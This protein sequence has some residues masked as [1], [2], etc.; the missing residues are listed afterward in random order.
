[1]III[2]YSLSVKNYSRGKGYASVSAAA[3]RS[4]ERLN[5]HY[6]GQIYDY[7]K[8]G[9][10][11]HRQIFLPSTAPK[12]YSNRETLWNEVER[13]EKRSNARLAKEV[14]VALPKELSLEDNIRMVDRYVTDNFINIG[15][16]ADVTIHDKGDGNPHAHILLTTRSVT[17]EGFNGNKDRSWD[18]KAV[19]VQWRR[20][21]A[22]YLNREY[23]RQGLDCR[24][25]HRSYKEQGIDREPT[26]HLGHRVLGLEREGIRTDRGDEYR[27]IVERNRIREEQEREERER[28]RERKRERS[29]DRGR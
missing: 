17:P 12:E 7:T 16:C 21:W 29:L 14:R 6:N 27:A 23:E 10:I 24:V 11:V 1:V 2:L 4:G 3:Y 18:T 28:Q 26:I 20:E 9:G 8:K 22:N 5:D 25:D 13:A 15:M 19:L